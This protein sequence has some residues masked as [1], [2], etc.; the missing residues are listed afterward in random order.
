MATTIMTM[1][2]NQVKIRKTQC[3][4]TLAKETCQTVEVSK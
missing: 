4:K 3:C 2:M 1:T